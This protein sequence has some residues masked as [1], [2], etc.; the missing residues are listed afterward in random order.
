MEN[1]AFIVNLSKISKVRRELTENFKNKYFG[2]SRFST[3]IRTSCP[4][5]YMCVC[6]Y[7]YLYIHIKYI[8]T[9]S[10]EDTL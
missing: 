1:P 7:I 2:G 8:S 5:L 10:M 6:N 9:F 3:Y 4:Y